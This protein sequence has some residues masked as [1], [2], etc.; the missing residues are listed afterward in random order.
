MHILLTGG[1]GFIGSTVTSELINQGHQV[2][3]LDSLEKGHLA[4]IHKEAKFIQGDLSSDRVLKRAFDL[5]PFDSVMHF[6][7]YIEAGE[8]MR[9]PG[10]FLRNNTGN[11]L[12]LIEAAADNKVPKFIFSSTAAVYGDPEYTPID[13]THPTRP[14]SAYGLAKLLADQALDW[15][16][17]LQGMTC[18]SL[19]YFNASGA[20]PQ[21]GE[22][23][24]PETHL[25]PLL[26][27][28]ALG[29]RPVFSLFGLDYPTPDGT[30]IRDY[31][32][33]IDLAQAHVLALESELPGARHIFNLG[34]GRGYSNQEVISAVERVTGRAIPWS[35]K[36]RRPGDPA[37]LIA[38]SQKIREQLGWIPSHPDLEDIIRDAW[39]W[40]LAHPMGYS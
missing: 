23:H 18:I 15:V 6:A 3:V 24:R 39:V 7:A 16:S 32:H 1:A 8:S 26:F 9:S 4:A 27:E 20:G 11:T 19:R 29:Q 31:I 17:R 13:E 12:R 22:D 14:T 33:I 28:T 37:V 40:K 35:A 36:P 21:F 10:R 34:N 25:I 2:V 38:S 30:C 5:G